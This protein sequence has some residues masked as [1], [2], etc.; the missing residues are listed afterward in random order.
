MHIALNFAMSID[1]KISDQHKGPVEFVSRSDRKRMDK[2]RA[3]YDAIVIGAGTLRAE[4]P[5]VK[6]Q[7]QKLKEMR[8]DAGKAVHPVAVIMS[9]TAKVP[10][11]GRFWKDPEVRRALVTPRHISDAT[12]ALNPM[13]DKCKVFCIGERSINLPEMCDALHNYYGTESMLVEGGGEVN[14]S[15][16]RDNLVDEIWATVCPVIIGGWAGPTPAG[17]L[18]FSP[19]KFP[20]F[21]LVDMETNDAGEIFLHYLRR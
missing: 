15:F 1:G 17:G 10:K 11:E 18:G 16:L 9:R 3:E 20:K 21:K 8:I 6:I 2:L 4:N 13:I 19:D 5:P 14:A 7:S 12:A